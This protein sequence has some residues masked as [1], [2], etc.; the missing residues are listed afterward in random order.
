MGIHEREKEVLAT[1]YC[2]RA[3]P[4]WYTDPLDSRVSRGPL[5]VHLILGVV[6]KPRWI[7]DDLMRLERWRGLFRTEELWLA[8]YRRRIRAVGNMREFRGVVL[9]QHR[10]GSLPP[11]RVQLATSR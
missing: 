6:G 7:T 10:F 8:R 5:R 9:L 11:P 2:C 4:A 1:A 3:A